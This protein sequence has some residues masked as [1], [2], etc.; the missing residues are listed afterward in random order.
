MRLLII[1]DEQAL[2]DLARASGGVQ[3]FGR[4]VPTLTELYREAIS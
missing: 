3:H 1:E 4:V 2:L